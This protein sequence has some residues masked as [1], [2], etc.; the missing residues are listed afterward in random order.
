MLSTIDLLISKTVNETTKEP[1]VDFVPTKDGQLQVL[2]A[3]NAV[4]QRAVLASFVQRGS[5]PQLPDIGVDW[6]EFLTSQRSAAEI[7]SQIFT[8]M[9]N[10]ANTY[11]YIPKYE[12]A[13]DKLTVTIEENK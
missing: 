8:A 3:E 1:I 7:N 4:K 11:D 9:H 2:Y 5:I 6:V 12:T 10:Y 13:D